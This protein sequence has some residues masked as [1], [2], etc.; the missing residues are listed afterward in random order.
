MTAAIEL[1]RD[2]AII[3]VSGVLVTLTAPAFDAQFV[4]LPAEPRP[5]IVEV[6][7]ISTFPSLT[8]LFSDRES[9]LNGRPH[10]S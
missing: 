1:V 7:E 10:E 5:H 9:A 8:P 3:T 6:I 4:S 2:M